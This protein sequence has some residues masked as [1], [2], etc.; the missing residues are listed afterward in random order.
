MEKYH[1]LIESANLHF[2]NADH[3]IFITYPL[4]NDPKLMMTIVEKLYTSV[5][6][7]IKAILHYDY[8]YKNIS[9]VPEKEEEQ[10][11][12][13]KEHTVKQYH[14]GKEILLA[15][16][17]LKDLVDFRKKSPIEFVRK[18]NFIVCSAGYTTKTINF[19]KIKKY[20][21]EIKYFLMQIN[22]VVKNGF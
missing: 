19:Q 11:K 8:L 18:N 21:Q 14:L 6:L 4:L 12:L 22:N 1:T 5:L 20:A 13:F 15:I 10:V 16:A 17:E 9:F 3:M 7:A 2:K